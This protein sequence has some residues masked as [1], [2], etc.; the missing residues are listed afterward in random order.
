[1][2]D[3]AAEACSHL[4]MPQLHCSSASA[5]TE[6]AVSAPASSSLFASAPRWPACRFGSGAPDAAQAA[7]SLLVGGSSGGLHLGTLSMDGLDVL[8]LSQPMEGLNGMQE[9]RGEQGSRAAGSGRQAGAG[10]AAA[11]GV[12]PF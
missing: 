3:P 1:M 7:R 5:P 11:A 8:G 10:E 12:R 9:A 2:L 6:A 4:E